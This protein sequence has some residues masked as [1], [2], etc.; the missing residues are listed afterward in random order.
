MSRTAFSLLQRPSKQYALGLFPTPIHRWNP[1]GIPED[2]EFWIKRDDLTGMQLSGN[3][4]RS[5]SSFNFCNIQTHSILPV[6]F[7]FCNHMTAAP[8]SALQVRKLEFLIAEA[9]AQ[10]ADTLITI[11]GIQSNHCR[12]T[13][14]SARCVL[15]LERPVTLLCRLMR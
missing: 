10:G 14:V 15:F 4:A 6:D 3:K 5:I 7:N 13:A 12:A 8:L 9:M 11:G 1:P 2:V